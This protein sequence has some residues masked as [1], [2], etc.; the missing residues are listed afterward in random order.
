MLPCDNLSVVIDLG[1]M[2]LTSTNK[3]SRPPAKLNVDA[4]LK[5]AVQSGT[6]VM[7]LAFAG[8]GKERAF[9]LV[10]FANT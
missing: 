3:S 8:A 9:R 10:Y 6:L 4:N 1:P 2:M 5:E 7:K